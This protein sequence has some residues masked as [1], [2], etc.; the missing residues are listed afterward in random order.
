[1]FYYKVFF[2]LSLVFL[3]SCFFQGRGQGSSGVSVQVVAQHSDSFLRTASGKPYIRL[4][5]EG[6]KICRARPFTIDILTGE[7]RRA[8]VSDEILDNFFPNALRESSAEGEASTTTE[9]EEEDP[10][11]E[12]SNQPV[13]TSVGNNWL[14]F[15]LLIQNNTDFALIINRV[16]LHGVGR[17]GGKTY[18]Y[19]SEIGNSYCSGNLPILYIVPPRQKIEYRP[20]SNNPFHNLKL[21]FAG[22]EIEDRRDDP[23][24]RLQNQVGN[25]NN[26]ETVDQVC[27]PQQDYGIPSYQ[28]EISLHGYFLA[29]G[30]E[31]ATINFFQRVYFSTEVIN[32]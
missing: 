8:G 24:R 28:L 11:Q 20:E 4:S 2:P 25:Q 15:G 10:E 27:Q 7:L 19:S 13:F 6:S 9:E 31:Y 18:N 32:F 29:L 1:M 23:S 3:S 17:C 14:E 5:G 30:E 16:R 26:Q 12:V 22:F 21:F